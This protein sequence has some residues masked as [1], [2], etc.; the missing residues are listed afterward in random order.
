MFTRRISHVP[1]EPV[2]RPPLGHGTRHQA[3]THRL[4][5]DGRGGDRG[6]CAVPA[7]D[8]PV[9]GSRR[10]KSEA[11]H[12]ADVRGTRERREAAGEEVE[13]RPVQAGPVD[14]PGPGDANDDLVGM[15][16]DRGGH[17]LPC[18]CCQLLRIVQRREVAARRTAER[19]GIERDSC[20]NEWAGQ[21]AA[22]RF[23]GPGDDPHAERAVEP[24][25]P[26]AGRRTT[27]A[28]AYARHDASGRRGRAHAPRAE[29]ADAPSRRD[30]TNGQPAAA[31]IWREPSGRWDHGVRDHVTARA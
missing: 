11:V 4:R 21:A 15:G 26:R 12:Q 22:A 20:R 30:D 28:P 7:D 1:I 18:P 29:F 14:R 10:R 3:I 5:D 31:G 6:R 2:V 19:M 25:E 23:V 13:V 17:L 27:R 16:Q 9:V 24:E 8:R